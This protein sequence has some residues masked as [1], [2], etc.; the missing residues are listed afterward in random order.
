MRGVA[1]GASLATAAVSMLVIPFAGSAFASAAAVT[2]VTATP[3]STYQTAGTTA[4]FQVTP[5]APVTTAGDI[6]VIV[7]SGPDADFASNGPN[8]FDGACQ[9]AGNFGTFTATPAKPVCGVPNTHGGGVDSVKIVA[10]KNSNG[11]ADGTDPFTMVQATFVGNLNSVT[12]TGP[13]S[14][15]QN[16]CAVYTVS[17]ADAGSRARFLQNIRIRAT[18]PAAPGSPVLSF[19]PAAA[20]LPAAMVT[21]TD[22]APLANVVEGDVVTGPQGQSVTFGLRSTSTNS[23]IAIDA[24][25]DTN[26]NHAVDPTE[27]SSSKSLTIT[28]GGN[29]GARTIVVTAPSPVFAGDPVSGTITVTNAAGDAVGGAQVEVARTGANPLAQTSLVT[30]QLG[31]IPFTYTAT[32]A[33][34]D[35]ITA[36]INQ[37]GGTASHDPTE[38][39]GT[40][41]ITVNGAS[42]PSA[43]DLTAA[44]TVAGGSNKPG[45]NA[46][47]AENAIEPLTHP[48]ETFTATVTDSASPFAPR[49]GITVRFTVPAHVSGSGTSADDFTP[50]TSTDVVT[51]AAGHAVFVLTDPSPVNGDAYRVLAT[52]A[53]GGASDDAFVLFQ[54]SSVESNAATNGG[55]GG[56]F[57][58]TTGSV[59]LNPPVVTTQVCTAQTFTATV[60][61]QY[62]AP[63]SG[64][65]AYFKVT[66]RNTI[67][68]GP[69]N[70]GNHTT[71]ASGVST[72]F[73]YTDTEAGCSTDETT[74]DQ[75]QVGAEDAAGKDNT[76]QAGEP[77]DVGYRYYTIAAPAAAAVEG[78]IGAPTQQFSGSTAP[79]NPVTS[80]DAANQ[81]INVSVPVGS[82]TPVNVFFEP[83]NATNSSHLPGSTVSVSSTG[84]G[85][86]VTP[87]SNAPLAS[88]Q[89]VTVD[90]SGFAQVKVLSTAT[91]T[92]TITGTINGQ[93]K[94][95]VITWTNAGTGRF[96]DLTPPTA[97][98]VIGGSQAFTTT[99][100]DL[101]GNPVSGTAINMSL[102]GPGQFGNGTNAISGSTDATGKYVV[103]VTVLASGPITVTSIGTGPEFSKAAGNPTGSAAGKGTDSST[104]NGSGAPTPS[105]AGSSL[106]LSPSSPQPND[107]VTAT[108]RVGD[109]TGAPIAGQNVRFT[110][111]GVTSASSGI[112]ATDSSGRA[113]FPFSSSSAGTATVTFSVLSGSVEQFHK[114]ASV[115]FG[116]RTP[117]LSLRTFSNQALGGGKSV[118]VLKATVNPANA[119]HT[120]TF[121]RRS[122]ITGV[123][124]PA[125]ESTVDSSGVATRII[126][127]SSGAIQ[128]IYSILRPNAGFNV[129]RSNDV[130]Y[131]FK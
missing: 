73:T 46:T 68:V 53:G 7:V 114:T 85:S 97:T 98:A 28:P 39:I 94:S 113:E 17:A 34:T 106:S 36:F 89:A 76:L 103:A 116:N 16:T 80:D 52:V 130:S 63:V 15:A 21:P 65:N 110:V 99:V 120:V 20:E 108:G 129:V 58:A 56:T 75:I 25:V 24:F 41:V 31:Q 62:A 11:L 84:V 33:G 23:P 90:A 125:G 93:T 112:L 32:N 57:G 14:A 100:T 5:D 13:S 124:V 61:D 55:V 131:K 70:D 12:L 81:A 91:G 71:D 102:T 117:S 50:A 19:C 43:I 82:Q 26:D 121:Y 83:R 118:V 88:P 101:Y 92:E 1:I 119:G 87:G 126:H 18:Q 49:Q 48:T 127:G 95:V 77:T 2:S 96:L 128:L 122:G 67:P 60:K 54:A 40:K 37:T 74:F 105:A 3:A 27:V 22:N 8:S 115:T 30:N 42:A 78:G 69:L 9:V 35:T 104:L 4:F 38:P 79:Y 111:S 64:A 59:T 107:I 86:L 47:V 72:G 29:D 45:A 44:G 123:V 51:D 66:G 10:D 6:S 109:S